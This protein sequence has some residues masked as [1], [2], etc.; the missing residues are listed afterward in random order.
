MTNRSKHGMSVCAALAVILAACT[1]H[2]ATPTAENEGQSAMTQATPPLPAGFV[3]T[4][5]VPQSQQQA[6]DT[7]LGYLTRTL[8]ALPAG[9]VVDASRYGM[10]GHK[11]DGTDLFSCLETLGRAVQAAREGH[12]PQLVVANLLRL[13][14]HGEHDDA[15]YVDPRL[16]ESNVGRD[17]LEVAAQLLIANDLT[18]AEEIA[19]WTVEAQTEVDQALSIAQREKGP[20]PNKEDWHAISTPHLVD[21]H[22]DEDNE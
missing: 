14:G 3:V 10:A 22:F 21:G 9:A 19:A 8:A 5:A 11:A 16:R 20:D 15:G 2:D 17:C 4:E 1:K 7:V 18:T 13:V 12:G 6:Q